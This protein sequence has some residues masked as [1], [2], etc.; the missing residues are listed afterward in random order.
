[1]YYAKREDTLILM[2]GG[3]DKG[4]QTTDIVKAK[5]RATMLED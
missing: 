2:L 3:G 5:Q 1:M 4:S